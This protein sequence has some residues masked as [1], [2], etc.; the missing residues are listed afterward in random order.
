MIKIKKGLDLPISGVP[1]QRIFNAPSVQ[2]VALNGPDYV[3]MKPTMLVQIGDKVKAGTP[4]FECKKTP[5]V[6]FTSPASGT[7]VAVNRGEKRVLLKLLV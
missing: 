3:G 4:L 2:T 6:L 7:V 1:S 5:G